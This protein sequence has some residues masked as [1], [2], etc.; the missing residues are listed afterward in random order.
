MEG[1][2][3]AVQVTGSQGAEGGRKRSGRDRPRDGGGRNCKGGHIKGF[4][5]TKKI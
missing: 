2:G 4:K 1:K 3:P 5:G